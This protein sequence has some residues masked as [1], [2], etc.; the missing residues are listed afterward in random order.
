MSCIGF[1][2]TLEEL[3]VRRELSYNFTR[4]TRDYESLESLPRWVQ[5]TLSDHAGDR[6][7]SRYSCRQLEGSKTHDPI[8]NACQLELTA[9]GKIHG[10]MRMYWGKKIIEWSGSHIDALES[11]IYL[12]NQ[13]GLDG[14]NPNSWTGILWCFGLH[15][16]PWGERTIF[17]KIRYMSGE[18]RQRKI[19][20]S[21]YIEQVKA[22]ASSE[23]FFA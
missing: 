12:N 22:R 2:P 16:R 9:T 13:Y 14:W 6:R 20:V 18:N 19:D 7:L 4:F 8:W 15:D 1:N 23:H 5:Q 17:G 11:M 3:V 21:R 10:Y